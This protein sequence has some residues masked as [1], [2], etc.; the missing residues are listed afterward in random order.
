MPLVETFCIWNYGP[1]ILTPS[2]LG[3]G[4]WTICI[5]RKV[6][7]PVSIIYALRLRYSLK[8]LSYTPISGIHKSIR[9]LSWLFI[10]LTAFIGAQHKKMDLLRAAAFAYNIVIITGNFLYFLVNFGFFFL[11]ALSINKIW[12]Q[13]WSKRKPFIQLLTEYSVGV[14]WEPEHKGKDQQVHAS[15]RKVHF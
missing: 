14:H 13:I 4:I 6:I 9:S 11:F 5:A 10:K 12:P 3:I 7:C 8:G 15:H 2:W 1:Q